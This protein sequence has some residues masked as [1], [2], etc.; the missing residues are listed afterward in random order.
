MLAAPLASAPNGKTRVRIVCAALGLM[1]GAGGQAM[2]A[3]ALPGGASSIQETYEDWRVFC[4]QQQDAK[5][6]TKP[7]C[8]LSQTQSNQKGQRVLV[9]EV[10]TA[11]GGKT[12]RGNLVLP[13][14]LQLEAGVRLQIDGRDKIGPNRFSTCLPS[15]CIVPL[16]FDGGTLAILRTAQKLNLD[17]RAV[18]GKA[19]GFSIS[20]K[21]FASALDRTVKLLS[22]K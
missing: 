2:A 5:Q 15:G 9:I 4:S 12:M 13:F 11:D 3:P 14:G 7:V 16:T 19:M 6:D 20:L 21:G 18:D 1:I 8:A 22:P 17:A 10:T